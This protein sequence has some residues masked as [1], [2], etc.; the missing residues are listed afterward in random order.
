MDTLAQR[1]VFYKI[2]FTSDKK[3]TPPFLPVQAEVRLFSKDALKVVGWLAS[4]IVQMLCADK[5]G[6]AVGNSGALHFSCVI[7]AGKIERF[8]CKNTVCLPNLQQR[9]RLIIMAHNSLVRHFSPGF[10]PGSGTGFE[11]LLY[12]RLT[13]RCYPG[14]TWIRP[15]FEPNVL[16]H[17]KGV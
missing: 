1:S 6:E 7:N 10:D 5:S 12:P 3:N 14:R 16:V 17:V 4:L 2:A 8:L 9:P 15:G 13:E 11:L